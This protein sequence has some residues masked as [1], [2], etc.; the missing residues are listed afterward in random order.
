MLRNHIKRQHFLILSNL[1]WYVTYHRKNST[2]AV[3]GSIIWHPPGIKNA[4]NLWQSSYRRSFSGLKVLVFKLLLL[5]ITVFFGEFFANTLFL[6]FIVEV[7]SFLIGDV[8]AVGLGDADF[9]CVDVGVA[10]VNWREFVCLPL[11]LAVGLLTCVDD[12]NAGSIIDVVSW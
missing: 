10:I 12:A 3:S 8:F 6:T 1:V 4:T 2:N 5:L 11:T 9:A 7:G